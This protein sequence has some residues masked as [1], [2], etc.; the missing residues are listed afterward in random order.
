MVY[1]VHPPERVAEVLR[2]NAEGLSCRK[3]ARRIGVDGFTKDSAYN[4]ICKHGAPRLK[5][6][7]VKIETTPEQDATI[8]HLRGVERMSFR[9]IGKIVGMAPNTV[10]SRAYALGLD[11]K[12]LNRMEIRVPEQKQDRRREPLPRFALLPL[13][14]IGLCVAGDPLPPEY[15]V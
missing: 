2:L 5:R 8:K 7:F 12:K 9:A 15:R 3:I 6:G 1:R 14:N 10:L 11:T 4:I 13:I